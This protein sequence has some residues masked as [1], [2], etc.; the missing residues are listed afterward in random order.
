MEGY[1]SLMYLIGEVRHPS[2]EIIAIYSKPRGKAAVYLL[3]M[4]K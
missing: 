4:E 1:A 3:F 2:L